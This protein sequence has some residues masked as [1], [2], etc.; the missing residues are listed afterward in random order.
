MGHLVRLELTRDEA[1]VLF[2][3][4]ARF[5]DNERLSIEDQAEKHALWNLHGLLEK[6][7]VELFDPHYSALLDAA[8]NRLRDPLE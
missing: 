7:L 2:E 1:L 6:Q 5:D 8:R 4:L 3:L